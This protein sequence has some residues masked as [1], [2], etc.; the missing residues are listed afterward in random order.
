MEVPEGAT[1]L[2]LN[3]NI[4]EPHYI[5][6]ISYNSIE[7]FDSRITACEDDILTINGQ[8]GTINGEITALQN[9][10]SHLQGAITTL[11][12][13]ITLQ[14]TG[15]IVM[16]G[17]AVDLKEGIYYT[18]NYRVYND[19]GINPPLPI[20]Y[21]NEIFIYI[22]DDD[23]F[24]SN[25]FTWQYQT[26]AWVQGM[27]SMYDNTLT[28]SRLRIPT[29]YAVYQAIQ[30]IS[31]S[32]VSLQK[33]GA[34]V[35]VMSASGNIIIDGSLV[36]LESGFYLCDYPIY[37]DSVGA[38]NRLFYLNEIVYYDSDDNA[39]YGTYQTAKY[40]SDYNE[41]S[42]FQCEYITNEVEDK[43]NRVITAQAV[44]NALEIIDRDM[45]LDHERI[46][47]SEHQISDLQQ[48]ED[49]VIFHNFTNQ[50]SYGYYIDTSVSV[51]TIVDTTPQALSPDTCYMIIKA[52]EG[53][54][55]KV[56]GKFPDN[57]IWCFTD[58]DFRIITK[59]TGTTTLLN[60]IIQAP[61]N[62]SYLIYNAT[63]TD[64]FTPFIEK[65]YPEDLY[66]LVNGKNKLNLLN[67]LKLNVHNNAIIDSCDSNNLTISGNNGWSGYSFV[68][69]NF[70]KNKNYTLS[71]DV[72]SETARK[73]GVTIQGT[74]NPDYSGMTTIYPEIIQEVEANQSVHLSNTINLGNY[75][76]IQLK[77]WSNCS[78]S[79][80]G[81]SGTIAYTN[82]QLE[83]GTSAS[84]YSDYNGGM[85]TKKD[86][87]EIMYDLIQGKNKLRMNPQT[88][89]NSGI[90]L[91]IDSDGTITING[92]ATANV[93]PTNLGKIVM[94]A[95]NTYNVSF[96]KLSGSMSGSAGAGMYF[97]NGASAYS[98]NYGGKALLN[99]GRD[100]PMTNVANATG[101]LY[102]QINNGQGFSNYKMKVQIVKNRTADYNYSEYTGGVLFKKD[103]ES[104]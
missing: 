1:K 104:Y 31:P 95:G 67:P 83:E 77:F 100:F 49:K 47:E 19:D 58:S 87:E 72:V 34:D 22:K 35:C 96:I 27:T 26:N 15:A 92:T 55:F 85:V 79:S 44:Y 28:N 102:C 98:N 73:V 17:I 20:I 43:R 18:G 21:E 38:S 97:S 62:A 46:L 86:F 29:C 81:S 76:Y 91:T 52:Q 70:G 80:I 45:S 53:N 93:H 64:N 33:F 5:Y 56:S 12:D 78:A 74:N 63:D 11:S 61:A 51:G 90:T 6:E 8:I 69:K 89:S 60:A 59:Y 40:D 14:E 82:I 39:F 4:N 103:V 101:Y 65:L 3:C 88:F 42:V 71:F 23:I 30:N 7:N 10:I 94:E 9:V 2:V 36:S 13:D 25:G 41:W 99:S 50:L 54:R 32:G 24:L 16:G 84:N 75:D 68:Y 37:L 66:N 48:N 57:P